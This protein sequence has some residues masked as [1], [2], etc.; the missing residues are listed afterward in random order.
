[1]KIKIHNNGEFTL[2]LVHKRVSIIRNIAK[3]L[4]LNSKEILD[5]SKFYNTIV[6]LGC[7]Y[8]RSKT[9]YMRFIREYIIPNI[10]K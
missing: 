10:I 8:F 2:D 6:V 7:I 9:D 5:K 1:M 3:L 4:N